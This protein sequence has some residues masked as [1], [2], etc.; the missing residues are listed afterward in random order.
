MSLHII[1]IEASVRYTY[2]SNNGK[3]GNTTV[4]ELGFT[5]SLQGVGISLF[6]KSQG[7]EEADRRK[8]AGKIIGSLTYDKEN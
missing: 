1:L 7:I 8:G 4:R 2:E 3:H 5:V 6:R